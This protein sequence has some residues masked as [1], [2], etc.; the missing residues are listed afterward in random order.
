MRHIERERV[1][2]VHCQTERMIG[3]YFTELSQGSLL[4]KLQN[5]IMGI[6]VMPDEELAETYRN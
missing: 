5:Y 6:T 1:K 3:D 2:L 4:I